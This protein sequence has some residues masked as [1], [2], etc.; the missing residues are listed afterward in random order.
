MSVPGRRVCLWGIIL[1]VLAL[2]AS[3]LSGV[4]LAFDMLSHFS[5]HYGLIIIA[6][7][8]GMLMPRFCLLTS[9]AVFFAGIIAIGSWPFNAAPAGA[10][11]PGNR[12]VKIMSFN[13]WQSNR[14]W[15]AVAREITRQDPDIVT[16]LEFGREK[17]RLLKALKKK[18]P[19]SVDCRKIVFCHM[20]IIS[21]YPFTRAKARVGWRGPPYVRAR[22]GPKLGNLLVFGVHTSRPPHYRSHMK[23][24]VA[25]A[26]RVSRNSGPRIV[27]GDFNATPFSRMTGE[28]ARLTGMSRITAIPSWPA[29]IAG[30]PQIAIDHMFISAKLKVVSAPHRGAS[31]GSDHYPLIATIAVKIR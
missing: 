2:L 6:C 18:Y 21:K 25:L 10:A 11:L 31:S 30:L 23:Q 27:M 22:F 1:A 19:Y 9:A 7:L 14:D 16:L 26:K 24:I 13:T 12:L 4:W 28:F 17:A 5:L 3:R 20:A 15:R 8:I 29:G